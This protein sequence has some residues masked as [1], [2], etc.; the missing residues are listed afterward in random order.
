MHLSIS[1]IILCKSYI[2][3]TLDIWN[4]SDLK[5]VFHNFLFLYVV[6]KN[7]V[8]FFRHIIII[9]ESYLS[10]RGSHIMLGY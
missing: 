6:Y 4:V 7:I 10:I 1:V 9:E 2:I 5:F 3:D 8:I